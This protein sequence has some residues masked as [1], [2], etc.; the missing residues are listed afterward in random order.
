ML[1]S[2]CGSVKCQSWQ[3]I[4]LSNKI[5]TA[6]AES[7]SQKA[8]ALWLAILTLL[9]ACWKQTQHVSWQELLPSLGAWAS[10]TPQPGVHALLI[11]WAADA[12]IQQTKS[13]SAQIPGGGG[14][15]ITSA[16]S[17]AQTAALL[18]ARDQSFA[19]P[20]ACFMF[21][22]RFCR[23]SH[24]NTRQASFQALLQVLQAGI[25][26]DQQQTL[27]LAALTCQFLTDAAQQVSQICTQLVMALAAPAAYALSCPVNTPLPS[28]WQRLVA[29]QPQQLAYQPD[30]LTKLLEWL[31]QSVPL[32]VS[33][34]NRT[35]G[36]SD[37]WLWRLLK[38]CQA[39]NPSLKLPM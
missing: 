6:A 16:Q 35:P 5:C 17:T 12:A 3:T 31:S 33:Q 37:E 13:C 7:L 15:D 27:G 32:I 39:G 29:L 20:P 25:A 19:F 36:N 14:T 24:A 4:I 23:S 21:F 26:A 30:Q 10:V 11:S 18:R 34:P 22:T 38:S 9:R 1:F 28:S 8:P 2:S